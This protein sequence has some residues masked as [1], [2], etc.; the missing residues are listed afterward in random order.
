M[1]VPDGSVWKLTSGGV[2]VGEKKKSARRRR[3]VCVYVRVDAQRT[4]EVRAR[5]R[6]PG[7]ERLRMAGTR[8][9]KK[10]RAQ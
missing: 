3:R 8:K 5:R 7:E 6:P 10:R 9:I 1:K 2:E 4:V